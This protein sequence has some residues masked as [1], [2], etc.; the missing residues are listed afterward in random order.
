MAHS[1]PVLRLAGGNWR[2][3]EWMLTL[4]KPSALLSPLEADGSIEADRLRRFTPGT[5]KSYHFLNA[6]TDG[7]P[8]T[9][10]IAVVHDEARARSSAENGTRGLR[11]VTIAL[12][13]SKFALLT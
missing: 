8:K 10:M 9:Q 7:T 3:F 13:S 4:S 2:L 1:F 6:V 12:P 5:N 11:G